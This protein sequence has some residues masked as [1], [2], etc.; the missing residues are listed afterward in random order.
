LSQ[1]LRSV[2]SFSFSLRKPHIAQPRGALHVVLWTC[3]ASWILYHQ[4][5][6]S[7]F[8]SANAVVTKLRN[9]ARDAGIM[10]VKFPHISPESLLDIWSDIIK[11]DYHAQNL[12]IAHATPDLAEM[13]TV[14][15]QQSYSLS[16]ITSMLSNMMREQEM[17]RQHRVSQ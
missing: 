7:E 11:R 3:T 17:D 1:E 9:S 4:K 12:E 15:N 6:T 14:I 16:Q 2:W 13:T 10:D 5:V 8:G